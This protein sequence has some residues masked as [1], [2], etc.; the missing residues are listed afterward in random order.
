MVEFI[1]GLEKARFQVHKSLIEH[2]WTIL[3][4]AFIASIPVDEE[5]WKSTYTLPDKDPKRFSLFLNWV[6]TPG[7]DLRRVAGELGLL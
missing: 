6:Y 3:E 4:S 2:V 7:I 5:G 1:V